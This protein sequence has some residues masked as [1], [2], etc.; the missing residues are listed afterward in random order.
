MNLKVLLHYV[1]TDQSVRINDVNLSSDSDKTKK[2]DLESGNKIND[3][4]DH[5]R[6]PIMST[7]IFSGAQQFKPEVD[8]ITTVTFSLTIALSI[9]WVIQ[10]VIGIICMIVYQSQSKFNPYIYIYTIVFTFKWLWA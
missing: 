8:M 5:P 3:Y 7:N 1:H 2:V 6:R 9:I 4:K 10:L